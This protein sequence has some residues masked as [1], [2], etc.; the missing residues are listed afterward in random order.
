MP[1]PSYN[2]LVHTPVNSDIATGT[3]AVVYEHKDLV[4]TLN[5]AAIHKAENDWR[6]YNSFLTTLKDQ[7]KDITE[8]LKQ[9]IMTKDRPQLVAQAAELIKTIGENP[10]GFFG[11]G[12]Y[13]EKLTKLQS[14]VAE[15]KQNNILDFA[16]RQFIARDPELNNEENNAIMEQF[17]NTPLGQRTPYTLKIGGKYDA[18]ALA[19][20]INEA[21][22][23][24]DYE[25]YYTPDNQFYGSV[26]KT[27]YDPAKYEQL[28]NAAF[29]AGAD[30]RNIPFAQT[31]EKMFLRSP[32]L[33]KR[34]ANS[35]DPVRESFVDYLK[36]KMLSDSE[37]RGEA[38]ANPNYLEKEKL[39]LAKS[40]LALDWAKF[41]Y[42]KE[43]DQ[44]GA[45][46]V[47]NEA[48]AIIDKGVET[49]VEAGGK[50]IKVLR[51]G[52]PTL[53][54][55]FGNIDKDGNVTNVPDAI[56]YDRDKDQVKLI[57][58]REDKTES[59]K[60]FIEKE[61]SLDQRT[62]LKEIAKRSF[63]NKDIGKV[64]ILV[65]DILNANGNS[66][67]QL[68]QKSGTVNINDVPAGTKLEKKGGKYYYQGKEVIIQ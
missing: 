51:I 16:H 55:N 8:V 35:K 44:F 36:S 66:L 31:W 24:Q 50:K 33:Q 13:L 1:E 27:K 67:Y 40:N 9:P 39:S 14:D 43:E 18:D 21:V 11:D 41:N 26:T 5:R 7:Y 12:Q 42:A 15:S 25:T 10:K 45:A 2:E 65:D 48:K 60:N 19:K 37:L 29:E 68:T 46:S 54:K 6:K 62:W 22:K 47:L 59:G 23:S 63:P 38:K 49:T 53:L 28:A 64:N 20:H 32:E 56:D 4:D 30:E 17:V 57:Y 58:Y 61:V 52:D 34:Y 3:Q